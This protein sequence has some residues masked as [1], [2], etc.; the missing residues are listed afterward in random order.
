MTIICL[1]CK[2]RG[3]GRPRAGTAGGR[4]RV[5]ESRAVLSRTMLRG[6]R[7]ATRTMLRIREC[8]KCRYRWRTYEVTIMP[9]R[10]KSKP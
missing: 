8:L 7:E 5:V 10:S 6:R 9:K 4:S 1:H 3:P 2:V